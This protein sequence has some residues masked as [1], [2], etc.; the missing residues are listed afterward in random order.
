MGSEMCI[1]D[2]FCCCP[3]SALTRSFQCPHSVLAVP[4]LG[5]SKD[6]VHVILFSRSVLLPGELQ[7]LRLLSAT[8]AAQCYSCCSV[9]QLLL[10]ATVIATVIAQCYS[11]CSV[12]QLIAQCYRLL[13]SPTNYCSC[14]SLVAGPWSGSGWKQS[15]VYLVMICDRWKRVFSYDL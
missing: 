9:L 14:C 6:E 1:R 12:P 5:P 8:V 11:Y 10:S 4:S 15:N 13:L 7:P 2:R 3:C